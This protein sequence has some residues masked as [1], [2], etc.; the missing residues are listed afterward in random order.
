[1]KK[2][3]N[4]PIF[5]NEDQERDFWGGVD[6]SNHYEQTDLVSAS[7]PNLKPT[8]KAISIRC[9]NHLFKE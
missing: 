9:R 1:M 2:P 8:T 6:L 4:L 3:L 7:F 5:E